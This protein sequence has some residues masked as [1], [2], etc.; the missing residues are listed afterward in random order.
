VAVV[1]LVGE[2]GLPL[3]RKKMWWAVLL[4]GG[5]PVESKKLLSWWKFGDPD[6]S[7]LC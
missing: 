1:G 3:Y 7:F 2:R 5:S 4:D 6:L